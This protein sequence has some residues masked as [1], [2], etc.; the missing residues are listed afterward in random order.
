MFV[1]NKDDKGNVIVKKTSSVGKTEQ[2]IFLI[3]RIPL[4]IREIARTMT[5]LAGIISHIITRIQRRLYVMEM[6]VITDTIMMKV[7]GMIRSFA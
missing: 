2:L 3:E 1:I 6:S 5:K 7:F 4:Q